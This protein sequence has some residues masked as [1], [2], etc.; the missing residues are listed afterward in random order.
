MV[1]LSHFHSGI[2]D[3]PRKIRANGRHQG[4]NS[5]WRFSFF[6]AQSIS[7]DIYFPWVIM[8]IA[9]ILTEQLQP[10]ALSLVQFLLNENV[11]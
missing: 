3:L 11:L 1:L 7:N 5:E 9:I 6:P 2:Q 4:S 8:N 10:L